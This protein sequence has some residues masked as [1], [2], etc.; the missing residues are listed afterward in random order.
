MARAEGGQCNYR[1][2][3]APIQTRAV[4]LAVALLCLGCL[5]AWQAL[6]V[7]YS[8]GGN[9]TALFLTGT[10]LKEVPPALQSENIYLFQN[11]GYDGQFYHYIAH[12]PFFQRNFSPY[13]DNARFRYRRP[14]CCRGWPGCWRLGTMAESM[15][16]T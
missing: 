16:H 5:A 6:T 8:Y 3:K 12:D 13:F 11:S 4:S 15:P 7:H 2:V 9:W 10:Q 1:E 14:F